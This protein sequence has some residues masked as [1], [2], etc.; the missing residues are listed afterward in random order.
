LIVPLQE[1]RAQEK[2]QTQQRAERDLG[3]IIRHPTTEDGTAIWELVRSTGVLDVNSCY[4]YLVLCEHFADT[5]LVAE[6]GGDIVGFVTGYR[7]PAQD[8]VVFVWQVGV[9]DKARKR[10]V[11]GQL[12][13]QLLTLPSCADVDYLETTISPS[14]QASQ[15]L[16]RALARD[17]STLCRVEEG[18]GKE[19]F[20]GHAQHE[21][22]LL[23]RIGPMRSS[24]PS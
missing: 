17:K 15:R 2:R 22:E 19:L 3:M 1:T 9:A 7:P 21:P 13:R 24:L 12:L 16:F 23:Y 5:C 14:N 11:A 20:P 8:D 10:G 4:A 18:F 6:W